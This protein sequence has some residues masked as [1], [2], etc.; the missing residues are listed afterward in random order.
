M[1]I[2]TSKIQWQLKILTNESTWILVKI[3]R[4]AL[5]KLSKKYE[6]NEKKF[7]NRKKHYSELSE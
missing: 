7:F 2:I 1:L 6:T 5:R 4:K 3:M